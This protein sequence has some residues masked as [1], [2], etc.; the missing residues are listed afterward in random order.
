MRAEFSK[1][2]ARFGRWDEELF[3]VPEEMRRTLQYHDWEAKKWRYSASLR[4]DAPSDIKDGLRAY[5][6]KKAQYRERQAHI[7][8]RQWYPLL[9]KSS[10][11][12]DTWPAHYLVSGKAAAAVASAAPKPRRRTKT[13]R[14]RDDDTSRDEDSEWTGGSDTEEAADD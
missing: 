1:C 13:T 12:A 4:S 7:F 6:A 8:A 3:L 10:I 14:R 9:V 11:S 2:H 5:A